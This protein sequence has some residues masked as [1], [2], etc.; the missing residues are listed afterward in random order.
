MDNNIRLLNVNIYL[1]CFMDGHEYYWFT[2]LLY[3]SLPL[4]LYLS[5]SIHL[6]IVE[7]GGLNNEREQLAYFLKRYDFYQIIRCIEISNGME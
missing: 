7:K 6:Y 4:S 3:L 5:L 2:L 1:S